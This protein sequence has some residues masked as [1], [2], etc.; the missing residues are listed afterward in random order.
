MNKLFLNQY[1]TIVLSVVFLVLFAN[2]SYLTYLLFSLTS[3]T[4]DY[5]ADTGFQIKFFETIFF[6]VIYLSV[7]LYFA[8]MAIMKFEVLEFG[9]ETKSKKSEESEDK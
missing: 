3:A 1:L 2:N 7:S 6:S 5:F 9:K 8:L 4:P